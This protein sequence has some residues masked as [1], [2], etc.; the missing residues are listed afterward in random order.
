MY[1]YKNSLDKRNKRSPKFENHDLI[2]VANLKRIF[3]K[4][5]TTIG[6]N[7]YIK[8]QKLFFDTIPSYKKH[9]NEALLKKAKLSLKGNNDVMKKLNIT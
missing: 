7:I 1:G 3:S 5:D 8:F 4:G 2:R 6:L 9:Y